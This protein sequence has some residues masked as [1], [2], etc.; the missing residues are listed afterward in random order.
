MVDK[1]NLRKAEKAVGNATQEKRLPKKLILKNLIEKGK[2]VGRLNSKEIEF[3]FNEFNFSD[4]DI[5]NFYFDLKNNK[6]EIY[7]DKT[8]DSFDVDSICKSEPYNINIDSTFICSELISK[9][10]K[11]GQLSKQEVEISLDELKLSKLQIENFYGELR[12]NKIVLIDNIEDFGDSDESLYNSTDIASSIESYSSV[13]NL[14]DP[15]KLYLKE[16][17]NVSL[18]TADE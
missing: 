2:L 5:S 13:I 1:L 6:I 4:K 8:V 9:G 7:T 11:N 10:K 15:I 18:L 17:G 14:A 3:C 16:I 12:K